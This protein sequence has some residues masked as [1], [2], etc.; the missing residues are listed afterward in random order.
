MISSFFSRYKDG[1]Q[2]T[3]NDRIKISNEKGKPTLQI[4][5]AKQTDSGSYSCVLTNNIGS[6]AEF[7]NVVVKGKKSFCF[8]FVFCSL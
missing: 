3:A 4:L 6:Q 8:V 2:L 7:S 1:Q 5:K